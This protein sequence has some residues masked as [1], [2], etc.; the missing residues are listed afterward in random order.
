MPKTL[1]EFA[2]ENNSKLI[3]KRDLKKSP[4][5]K[6]TFVSINN[7]LYG[8]LKYADT[9]TRARSKEI[10]N[11][12]L[13]KL[14][15]EINKSPE[16]E[17]DIYIR[18]EETEQELLERIQTFFQLNVKK[19][20]PDIMGEN[21]QITL[22]K[23]LLFIIIKELEHISLLESSKDIL[24]DAFEIFVSK[25]LKDEGGQFFT[26][27]NIAK[28]MVNYLDPEEDSKVLD[29]ACGHGGFLL[30]TKE[31][32]WS[33]IDNEQKKVKI[34]SN[35]YGIDKDLFL[36]RICK[37][38]LEILSSGKSNVFCEDSLDINSYRDQAKKVIKNNY[39][40]SILTN[41]PFGAKIPINNKKILNEYEFGHLWKNIDGNWQKQEKIVKQQ[42]PQILFIERCVQL[43][44]DGGKLGI[45]LPEGIFGNPS[46]RY[47]WDFLKSN[48]KIL[49]IISLDQNTFQP[50]TCNKTSI[51]FF[52]K[53][54][55]I[56]KNYKIDFAI[57][58]NVG[59]DK[60]GKTQ[61]ILNKDGTKKLD[62]DKNPI[63]NDD[64]IDLH[65]KLKNTED[66]NYQKEQKLFK[67]NFS[68][69]KN[70]IFI[71]S[72]YIGVEKPLKALENNI[73]FQLIS[74][75][76]L[77]NKKII[78]TKNKGYIPR[79]DEIG[80]H[81]YGLGD[82]PFIRT[83]EI[84]NWEVDLNSHKKTSNEVYD[85]FK[86]KQNIEIGDIL[87]VKD[88]GPNL[89]GNTAFIS[90]LDTRII[91]QSHIFQIKTL[92]NN[93]N[94]DSYLLLYLL[95]LDIVQKQIK[96]ITFVQGTIAT[97]GNRIMDVIL[98][99][100]SEIN[101]R[102]EISNDIKEI[103]DNKTEIRKK[104]NKLSINYFSD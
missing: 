75:G 71:P 74:I 42:P 2:Q 86:D 45:V 88:G 47:I 53:L 55:D 52:Q 41:P 4:N 19:K 84:N 68:Q 57:V 81:V 72:Y 44:K 22:N 101:K 65:L 10:I 13:C 12:L 28:F 25:M 94:I 70:K 32:L 91:I 9:D 46:D 87:L 63:I 102:K 26:P 31:L 38:Y 83:S 104:I 61:Y 92:K 90:E 18:E 49:G 69:I 82:I 89:I 51:L 14:V 60:D 66:F 50:Y 5:L 23:D 80:S 27:P 76:D 15:D 56:P 96:A 7:H 30:E 6:K 24:S 34:I 48:G 39:F 100:P 103:I 64:L 20:Y 79:G 8:K 54:K 1:E 99:I 17:M 29:P 77:I 67:I 40:D 33:K 95:N 59:H 43:L 21:E 93:E 98:P 78:Y 58:D 37:L 3:R 35:L 97:I 16:D 11:L 62:Q 73:N 36:A 85:Q